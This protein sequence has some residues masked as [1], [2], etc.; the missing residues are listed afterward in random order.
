[1]EKM[2]KVAENIVGPYV[3]GKSCD[4]L[5]A[6]PSFPFGGMENPNMIFV[7]P[8]LLVIN[9][10]AEAYL[11]QYVYLIVVIIVV[12]VVILLFLL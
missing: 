5:V 8:T 3:W 9:D 10:Q 11:M 6:P 12:I 7:T 2:I 4:L 1:M